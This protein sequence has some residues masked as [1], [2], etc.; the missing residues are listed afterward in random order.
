MGTLFYW[1]C[2]SGNRIGQ[3]PRLKSGSKA[4]KNKKQRPWCH[5]AGLAAW[6]GQKKHNQR[7]GKT[8][9]LRA[10]TPHKPCRGRNMW[11]EGK[12]RSRKHPILSY[13]L[14]WI[15]KAPATDVTSATSQLVR[16]VGKT[17]AVCST[18]LFLIFLPWLTAPQVSASIKNTSPHLSLWSCGKIPGFDVRP[19]WVQ[20][21]VL[22][23]VSLWYWA[24]N[25]IFRSFSFL[26]FKM[27]MILSTS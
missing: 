3:A 5:R 22:L 16:V 19:T 9:F 11:G 14:L 25:L 26:L 17:V 23:F 2:A 24:G 21:Q 12:K 20:I 1:R 15:L 13:L 6:G 27:D 10:A 7:Q 8:V 4:P 18:C